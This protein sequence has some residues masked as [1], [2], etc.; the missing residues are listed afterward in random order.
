VGEPAAA[1]LDQQIA[2][3]A[4]M[5]ADQPLATADPLGA[6][7]LRS[8]RAQATL[9]VS[10]CQGVSAAASDLRIGARSPPKC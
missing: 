1:D 5:C 10:S 8:I 7:S 6:V 2:A 4:A 9:S 3:L